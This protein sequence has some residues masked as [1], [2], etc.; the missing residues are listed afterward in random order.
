[1]S[2]TAIASLRSR[3]ALSYVSGEL[4]SQTGTYISVLAQSW[5]VLEATHDPLALGILM[6]ARYGPAAVLAPALGRYVDRVNPRPLVLLANY[7]QAALA[8]LLVFMAFTPDTLLFVPFVLAGSVSQVFAMLEHSARMSYMAAIVPD[9]VRA[10][11]AGATSSAGTLGRIIGPALASLLLLIGPSGLCFAVNVL[12]FLIAALLLP[13]PRYSVP[14]PVPEGNLRDGLKVIW[15]L[16]A[17]R[18]L[19][20]VFSLVSL[21]SFNVATTLPLLVQSNYLNDPRALAALN[22]AFGLGSFLGGLVRLWLRT[23]PATSSFAGLLLFGIP[24]A[25]IGIVHSIEWVLALLFLS[26]F[27]RLMFSASA[28]A[29]LAVGVAQ[30]RRGLVGSLYAVAFTGTTPLGALMVTVLV[31]QAGVSATM[32]VCGVVAVLGGL[33]YGGLLY[34]RK[35]A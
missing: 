33:V 19:L 34:L 13:R 24:F 8:G 17:V 23:G 15:A 5:I 1:M 4:A 29:V 3:A 18:D 32:V 10:R 2:P 22:I 16:P 11:F 25:G 28:E 26:G 14:R 12:T 20:I 27:G 35:R 30:E 6:A 21:V 7:A 9:E 31:D